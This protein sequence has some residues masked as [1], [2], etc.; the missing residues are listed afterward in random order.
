MNNVIEFGTINKKDVFEKKQKE[1]DNFKI[2]EFNGFELTP[3][4]QKRY[5][6]V[7]KWIISHQ[8]KWLN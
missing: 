5:D 6:N 3:Q 4:E 8:D 7:H 2:N 1:F